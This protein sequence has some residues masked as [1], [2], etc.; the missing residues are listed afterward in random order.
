MTEIL[1]SLEFAFLKNDTLSFYRNYSIVKNADNHKNQITI[2]NNSNSNN[3][4]TTH[5]GLQIDAD[6]N[7]D[8]QN[9]SFTKE[10]VNNMLVIQKFWHPV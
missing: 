4:K 8:G 7:I 6:K 10:L 5:T 2:K 3:T 9:N 1:S